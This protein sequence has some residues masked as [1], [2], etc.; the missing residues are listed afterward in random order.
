MLSTPEGIIIPFRELV[1]NL[2]IQR[3]V[4]ERRFVDERS[5]LHHYPHYYHHLPRTSL[6][7][8]LDSCQYY[9]PEREVLKE[10]IKLS[11]LQ[12]ERIMGRVIEAP[13]IVS[14]S[15]E[16]SYK[17]DFK[18]VV[19]DDVYY[20]FSLG[21]DLFLAKR[22]GDIVKVF[23]VFRDGDKMLALPIYEVEV[24]KVER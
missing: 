6:S 24:S 2:S 21:S 11:G 12:V 5:S 16:G 7:L 20:L 3:F 13:T 9:P 4:Y 8:Q 19:R 17:L 1:P 18:K 15:S 14:I 23:E 22:D 10:I